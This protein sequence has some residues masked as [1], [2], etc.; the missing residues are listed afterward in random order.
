M[1]DVFICNVNRHYNVMVTCG[2][3]L[4]KEK[5]IRPKIKISVHSVVPI[6]G[7]NSNVFCPEVG[8]QAT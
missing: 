6:V 1:T 8:T 4:K 3:Q 7:L 5:P 2:R